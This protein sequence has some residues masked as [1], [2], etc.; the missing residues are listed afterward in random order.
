MEST[1]QAEQG[2]PLGFR[3]ES[4]TYT[5]TPVAPPGVPRGAEEPLA[6]DK[7]SPVLGPGQ[8]SPVIVSQ[9]SGRNK[10]PNWE[11]NWEAGVGIKD[12]KGRGLPELL[13]WGPQ[14]G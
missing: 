3:Q 2:A 10:P 14:R 8:G 7:E 9:N 13:P 12:S 6:Q 1:F 11:E 5:L 4:P